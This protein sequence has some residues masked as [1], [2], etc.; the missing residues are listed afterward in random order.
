MLR[1]FVKFIQVQFA[2]DSIND[3]FGLCR[4]AEKLAKLV[5]LSCN[6]AIRPQVVHRCV[7]CLV[8]LISQ[9]ETT[10]SCSD[11]SNSFT[12]MIR[13]PKN[14]NSVIQTRKCK[15]VWIVAFRK[16]L[17]ESL[18]LTSKISLRQVL[19]HNRNTCQKTC[20]FGYV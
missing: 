10:M 2:K 12:L 18:L 16:K 5:I 8:K 9:R 19:K 3:F 6:I 13:Y 4:L 20:L 17:I 1:F 14:S 11:Q 15:L 7:D